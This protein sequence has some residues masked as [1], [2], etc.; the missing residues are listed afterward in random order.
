MDNRDLHGCGVGYPQR[1][2]SSEPSPVRGA[3]LE[4]SKST[5]HHNRRVDFSRKLGETIG[6]H[7]R[8][9]HRKPRRQ[10]ATADSSHRPHAHDRVA[11]TGLISRESQNNP[12]QDLPLLRVLATSV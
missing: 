12:H 6:R 4:D 9:P 1:R 5:L 8:V 3:A 7:M 11:S 2:L 10:F